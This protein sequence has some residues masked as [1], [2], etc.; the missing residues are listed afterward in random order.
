MISATIAV[1][2]VWAEVPYAFTAGTLV[3]ASEVNANFKYVNYGNIVIAGSD[4]VVLGSYLGTVFLQN[5]SNGLSYLNDN[6]FL[7][8]LDGGS[9]LGI[10]VN[11]TGLNCSGDSYTDSI[12]TDNKFPITAGTIWGNGGLLYYVPLDG[13]G[14]VNVTVNSH[15]LGGMCYN[16]VGPFTKSMVRIYPNNQAITGESTRSKSSPYRIFR[17][18]N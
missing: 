2:N 4:N 12:S 9:V 6:G 11:F 17:R 16:L 13:G 14:E 1:T 15:N 7:V 3:R 8:C 18:N 5:N 10:I